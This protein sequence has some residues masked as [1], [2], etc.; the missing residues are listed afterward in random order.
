MTV[1]KMLAQVAMLAM[2]AGSVFVS[3]ATSA[4]AGGAGSAE[5]FIVHGLPGAGKVDICIGGEGEVAGGV[6]YATRVREV[7]AAGKR[8]IKFRKAS[9]GQCKGVVVASGGLN[10]LDG[11]NRTVV[12]SLVAGKPKFTSFANDVSPTGG[13]NRITAAH[14][15]SAGTLDVLDDEQVLISGLAAGSVATNT[16]GAGGVY[17]LWAAKTGSTDAVAGPRLV[18]D[19]QAGYAFTVVLVGTNKAATRQIVVFKQKAEV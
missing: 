2:V 1:R 18:T 3:G 4:S 19:T 14:K 9:K 7:V 10:T 12:A 8:T 6:S 16:M 17:S 15:M 11:A 13:Q 5:L